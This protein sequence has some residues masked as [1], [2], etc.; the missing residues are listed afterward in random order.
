MTQIHDA[1]KTNYDAL[2]LSYAAGN[3]DEA[4]SLIVAAHLAYSKE[5]RLLVK[6]CETIGGALINESCNPVSM[7]GDALESVLSRL[8]NDPIE[9]PQENTP[10]N[11][12]L[13]FDIPISLAQT[14]C[15]NPKT[16][17]WHTLFPGM[18]TH[19]INLDCKHSIARFM[20]AAPGTKSPHHSHGGTEITLVLDGAFKDETGEYKVGDLIVT[21]E[22]M[23]HT[24]LAC[25]IMGCTCL[26]VSS[27]PIKLKGF[28][29]F[30]NP[31]LRA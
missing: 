6:H 3:L 17:K 30:L 7:N 22:D 19:D 23:D 13:P 11:A 1:L 15:K 25:E 27:A 21:D 4:Q 12:T 18:Q 10:A 20:K 5:A 14:L 29:R 31:F 2:L 8:D 9:A 24:P 26:V 28:G 16:M